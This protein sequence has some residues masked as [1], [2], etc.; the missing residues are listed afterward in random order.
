MRF[1]LAII[2]ALSAC[3][4]ENPS[5]GTARYREAVGKFIETEDTAH[6]RLAKQIG[7]DD[8]ISYEEAGLAIDSMVDRLLKVRE[9]MRAIRLV[10]HLPS[11]YSADALLTNA[12]L[13]YQEFSAP[14]A[15]AKFLRQYYDSPH[16][17]RNYPAPFRSSTC[18]PAY[19]GALAKEIIT[20]CPYPVPKPDPMSQWFLV[21]IAE[22]DNP[23]RC[24]NQLAYKAA[25][26]A[27]TQ[28]RDPACCKAGYSAC[29]EAAQQVIS[30]TREWHARDT[31][32]DDNDP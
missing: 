14:E 19:Y 29:E 5:K 18:A 16:N 25:E 21:Q 10:R 12:T 27:V 24:Y 28:Y 22:A 30:L 26:V 6:L 1:L 4:T 2:L 3:Q 32:K 31:K 9:Y 17:V 13:Y 15:G 11:K 20:V 8:M 7:R 23:S